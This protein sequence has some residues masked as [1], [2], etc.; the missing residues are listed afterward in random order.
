MSRV[1]KCFEGSAGT[2]QVFI[3]GCGRDAHPSPCGRW[4]RRS[5]DRMPLRPLTGCRRRA[6]LL[7]PDEVL[8]PTG[9]GASRPQACSIHRST[10]DRPQGSGAVRRASP[11]ARGVDDAPAAGLGCRRA[12]VR[13]SRSGAYGPTCMICADVPTSK[14]STLSAGARSGS[15]LVL[16][17][18]SCSVS[19][20]TLPRRG[21]DHQGPPPGLAGGSACGRGRGGS[22]RLRT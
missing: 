19:S 8:G 20:G 22:S 16:A 6:R 13:L 4:P 7:D 5:R 10:Q 18:S 15:S 21:A 9:T 11:R 12:A 17:D 14:H 1:R 3:R 2:H